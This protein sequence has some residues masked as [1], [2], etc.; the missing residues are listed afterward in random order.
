MGSEMCIRDSAASVLLESFLFYTGFFAPLKLASEGR[1]TNTADII[2]LI[3]RDEGVH[4]FYIGHKYQNH[5][6]RSDET[7]AVVREVL[8]ELYSIELLR[9]QDLYDE[10]GWTE[11]VKRYLR[12]NANKALANLGLD[13]MFGPEHTEI[14]AYIMSAL[15]ISGTETFDFFSGSGSNYVIGKVELTDD[16]D[17]EW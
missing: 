17:W 5:P 2:R 13:P 3:M 9:C 6:E 11:D 7:D 12:Y 1:L 10:V 14:P 8:H 16:K 15:D 4:G